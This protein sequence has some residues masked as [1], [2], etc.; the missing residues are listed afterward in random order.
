MDLV[1]ALEPKSIAVIGASRNP[2]KV[3]SAVLKN[4]II[5]FRGRIY[6]VNNQTDEIQSLKAYKSILSIKD[7]VDIAVI[8]VPAE[9]VL[10]VLKECERKKVKLSIIVSAGFAEVG[11]NGL[12]MQKEMESFLS[13]ANI[14]VVGPN[15]LGIINTDPIFNATFIDPSSKPLKGSAGF[16]SQSGAILSAVVDDASMNNIGFSKIFSIGNAVD[17][18]EADIMD[19]LRDDEKTKIM[20]IY[21]E[22]VKNAPRFMKSVTEFARKKPVIILKGGKSETTSSAVSS[23]TGSLAGNYKAYELAF[24]KAGVIAIN[25]IDDLFNLIRDAPTLRIDNDQVI[26]ITNAGGGGVVTADHLI[27]AGLELM[28]FDQKT[29]SELKSL[30]PPEANIHNPVD[31]VGD[32]TPER[33]RDTLN[34]LSRLKRPIIVIFSPQEM[35]MPIETAKEIYEAHL[36]NP[37]IPILSVFLGGT[38]V[39]KARRFLL[40][41]G[42]PIYSYPNEAVDVI[43]GIYNYYTHKE[44]TFNAYSA[45]KYKSRKISINKNTFGLK[46][47]KIFDSFGFSTTNGE[48]TDKKKDILRIAKKIGYPCVLKVASDQIPHKNKVG[49]VIVGINSDEQL[50]Q[51]VSTLDS[52]LQSEGIKKFGYELYEDANKFGET[53]IEVLLGGHRDP[54]FGPMVGL[55]FG[56][57]YANELNEMEF[58]LSPMS[59]KEISNLKN[60]KIGRVLSK[61]ADPAVFN[62]II[63]YVVK[64]SHFMDANPQIKDIDL[65]PLLVFKN[66]AVAAD[67]K[68]F[69]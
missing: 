4:L 12:K 22:G 58:V 50:M 21:I 23:H 68:I 1:K 6:P 38:R 7:D 63:D 34:V 15:C 33:Y 43:K 32:A 47:K 52:N 17:V 20:S 31:I 28:Q 40:E 37:Q 26:I 59:D 29:T 24:N 11:G 13:K 45:K 3:G 39:D 44:P 35:S 2:N 19:A 51:A 57:I 14:R 48:A 65:N 66:K 41:K 16:I 36:R 46:A 54:Q 42:M 60:S 55:G 18:D 61:S 10:K 5:S 9:S 56:G 25:N 69:V 8:A 62:E 30:L 49:G 64:L 27:Q 67:F 53:P